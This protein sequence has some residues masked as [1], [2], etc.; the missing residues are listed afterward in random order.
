MSACSRFLHLLFIPSV[1][2]FG[3]FSTPAEANMVA[4]ATFVEGRTLVFPLDSIEDLVIQK[5]HRFAEGDRVVTLEGAKVKIRFEDGST[6]I[7][8]PKTQM[9]I[10][11]MRKTE[12]GST[13][14]SFRLVV[15]KMRSLVAKLSGKD[16]RFEYVT[17]TSICGVAG[18]D[19][20][21][22]VADGKTR[23]YMG[24]KGVG[25]VYPNKEGIDLLKEADLLTPNESVN[26][27]RGN[28][29]SPVFAQRGD[30][31]V[32]YWL[33]RPGMEDYRALKNSTFWGQTGFLDRD[34]TEK[35]IGENG[36]GATGSAWESSLKARRNATWVKNSDSRM[37][38]AT[39]FAGD[40][41]PSP[42]VA[43]GSINQFSQQLRLLST[44]A[45][46]GD[47]PNASILAASIAGRDMD[48]AAMKELASTHSSDAPLIVAVVMNS[49]ASQNAGAIAGAITSGA[50][51]AAAK[52]ASVLA[53]MAPDQGVAI[54]LQAA[55]N[56]PDQV[57]QI[58][59]N[60]AAINSSLVVD[61]VAQIG[62]VYPERLMD[63][64][65][66]V[67]ALNPDL[68]AQI[69]NAVQQIDPAVTA[70]DLVNAATAAANIASIA[71]NEKA[72]AGNVV[73][74]GQ[75]AAQN[76]ANNYKPTTNSV[77][78]NAENKAAKSSKNGNGNGN[79]NG[80]GDGNS[81]SGDTPPTEN[82]GQS[83][84]KG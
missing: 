49:A 26:L 55:T 36:V 35:T 64:A 25:L 71:K 68:A 37:L 29:F 79:G 19:V 27:A 10:R 22:E 30:E 14:F 13:I 41:T 42:V 50:P 24:S 40:I 51:G 78:Q 69:L 54:A 4:E 11:G 8:E 76:A 16:S 62:A 83:I 33:D 74:Q 21:A 9:F 2:F 23:F 56:S 66:S 32:G 72:S 5:G 58:V 15:G 39:N 81:P 18:A 59:A 3:L 80:S 47:I 7:L 34:E 73:I 46:G 65:G 48:T 82:P 31:G 61:L 67:A 52:V 77:N 43:A 6:T 28:L 45:S 1:F 53:T 20:G 17:N 38:L 12:N 75:A 44:D 60:I 63:I 70:T 57:A 84:S